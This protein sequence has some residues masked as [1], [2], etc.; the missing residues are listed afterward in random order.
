MKDKYIDHY[1]IDSLPNL[2]EASK[3][4]IP[5]FLTINKP[6]LEDRKE[7]EK[8]FKIKIMTPLELVKKEK[9]KCKECLELAKKA[10]SEADNEIRR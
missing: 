1:G 8:K 7:L 10:E 5:I 9:M 3:H 4:R 2:I 6:L